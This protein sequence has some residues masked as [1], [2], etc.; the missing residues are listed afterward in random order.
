MI[1]YKD[2]TY[3]DRKVISVYSDGI[4]DDLLMMVVNKDGT[5]SELPILTYFS[6]GYLDPILE[7]ENHTNE[8]EMVYED[9]KF[10][11]IKAFYEHKKAEKIAELDAR[12]C[13]AF[14]KGDEVEVFKGRKVPIG[15]QFTIHGIDRFDVPGTYGHQ[16]TLYAFGKVDGKWVK[17]NVENLKLTKSFFDEEVF[18]HDFVNLYHSV[19]VRSSTVKWF[20]DHQVTRG[21]CDRDLSSCKLRTK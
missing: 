4:Y 19:C 12:S 14:D 5:Y 9:A 1:I 11:D 16:Y 6:T 18:R 15:T 13:Y 7:A 8:I 21:T 10:D 3:D 17:T 2:G 20:V